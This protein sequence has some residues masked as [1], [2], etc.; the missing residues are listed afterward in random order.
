MLNPTTIKLASMAIGFCSSRV[1]SSI[2]RNALV[3]QTPMQSVQIFIGAA[4]VGMAVGRAASTNFEATVAEVET[5]VVEI[6]T[7]LNNQKQNQA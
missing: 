6:K 2:I 4:G 7:Q 3:A 1:T 5:A